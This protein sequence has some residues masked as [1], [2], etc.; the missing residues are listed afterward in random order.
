MTYFAAGQTV[1]KFPSDEG[2]PSQTFAP[3][4]AVNTGWDLQD[5]QTVYVIDNFD[6]FRVD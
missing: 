4:T 1:G 3:N 6:Y 5:G 2:D